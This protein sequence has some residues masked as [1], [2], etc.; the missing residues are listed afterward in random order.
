MDLLSRLMEDEGFR[1]YAYLCP[2]GR[3]TVGYGRNIDPDGGRGIS[4]A[5]ALMLLSHDIQEC[6]QDVREFYGPILWDRIGQ[7]RRD[8]LVNMR[9]QLGPKGFRKFELMHDA[10]R[11]GDWER[12]ANEAQSSLWA[13]QTRNRASRIVQELRS[14]V[15]L[16]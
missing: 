15:S 8:A 4:Q 5:E 11:S 16:Y 12:A 1:S 6:E 9:F 7:V 3:L 10:V 2:A 13:T 14:G